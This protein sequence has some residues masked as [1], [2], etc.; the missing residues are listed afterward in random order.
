VLEQPAVQRTNMQFNFTA[1]PGL[2]YVV[3]SSVDFTNWTALST[4]VATNGMCGAIC[5]QSAADDYRFYRVR[6]LGP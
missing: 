4:N 3:E 1:N 6:R 2:K 5:P